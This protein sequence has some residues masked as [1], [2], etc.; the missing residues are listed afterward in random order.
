M[1]Y[2]TPTH[3][4]IL[5]VLNQAGVVVYINNHKIC[6]TRKY[7]GYVL[8]AKD[9]N[10]HTNRTQFVLCENVIQSNYVDWQGELNRT[11][12]HESIHIAQACKQGNG[13]IKPLGFRDDIEKE[14]NAVQD[15]PREVLRILKKYCL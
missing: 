9:P 6:N 7:D 11:I 12:A 13:N 5:D 10:N 1:D 15:Q 14:A 2:L 3:Q 4:Q 8:T